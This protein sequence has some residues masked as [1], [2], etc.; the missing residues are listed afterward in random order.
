MRPER[1]ANRWLLFIGE[2][3][4]AWRFTFAAQPIRG[5]MRKCGEMTPLPFFWRTDGGTY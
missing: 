1:E 2:V 5:V 3:K 4:N